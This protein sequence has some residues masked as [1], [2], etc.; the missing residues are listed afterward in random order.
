ML[1]MKKLITTFWHILDRQALFIDTPPDYST[2]PDGRRNGGIS[3][4]NTD[5][6]IKVWFN[7]T[8]LNR[9]E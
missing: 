9:K 3:R 6:R 4:T 1:Q 5:N 7:A 2:K 8:V